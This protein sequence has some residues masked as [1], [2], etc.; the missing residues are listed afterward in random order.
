[1]NIQQWFQVWKQ[2]KNIKNHVYSMVVAL[3]KFGIVINIMWI[4]RISVTLS[5]QQSW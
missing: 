1:M 3:N 2:G 4:L 5:S